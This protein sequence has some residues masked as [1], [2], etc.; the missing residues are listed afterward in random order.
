MHL[1]PSTIASAAQVLQRHLGLSDGEAR[2]MLDALHNGRP[3][4]L[5]DLDG[6]AR[7]RL[8]K[9]LEHLGYMTK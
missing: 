4:V 3:V 7:V 6:R 2:D 8:Q 5:K 1:R 9:H